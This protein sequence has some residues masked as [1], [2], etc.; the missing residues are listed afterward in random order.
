MKKH[1][2]LPKKLV[3]L[4]AFLALSAALT[5]LSLTAAN[6]DG[7]VSA[8][9]KCD[10]FSYLIGASSTGWGGWGENCLF[11]PSSVDLSDLTLTYQGSGVAT[12]KGEQYMDGDE[13]SVDASSGSVELNINGRG[14][15][16]LRVMTGGS[17]P[18]V[19]INLDGGD[20]AFRA[21]CADKS[22]EEP[23]DLYMVSTDGGV[24]YAGGLEKFKGHG[25]T[26]FVASGDTNNKN[27][28][29]IKLESKAELIPG[30]GNIKKWVL[31][32][33]RMYDGS[34]DS[35]GLSQLLAFHTFTGLAGDEY[36]GMK[37]E[38]VDLYVNGDYR[39]AYVLCE[40]MNDGGAIDV[41]DLDEEVTGEGNLRTVNDRDD[42]AIKLGVREYTYS[43]DASLSSD[44]TDIT[45][46]YVLEVMFGMYEGCGFV[47]KAGVYFSVK[48]PE[49]CTKEMVQYIAKKVQ[50]FENAISS[51]TG[52]DEMGLHYTD[53]ADM[54]SLA[55]MV[56]VYAFYNNFEYFRTSTYIY[57]DADGEPHD[58]LTF[59]PVWDFETTSWELLNSNTFFDTTFTY[60]NEQQYTWSE[61]LWQHGDFM[62]EMY[63]ENQK[64]MSVLDG[65]IAD[66]D[67]MI[68]DVNASQEMSARRW[69]NMGYSDAA[70]EYKSAVNHRYDVWFNRIWGKDNLLYLD[71]K[72][73]VNDDGTITMEADT[74][75]TSNGSYSW[76][77]LTEGDPTKFELF[78][79][80]SESVTVPSDGRLYFC[81]AAGNNNAYIDYTSSQ[82]FSRTDITMRSAPVKAVA[83]ALTP[84]PPPET[85]AETEAPA[86]EDSGGC[87]SSGGAAQML[88]ITVFVPAAAFI[89]K[90]KKYA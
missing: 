66:M 71:I 76:Y 16:I 84:P 48:S 40:R 83:E 30:S 58:K 45:G 8:V 23:G 20:D 29:N 4:T 65:V 17:I 55:D 77:V 88:I 28:Y 56:L 22:H 43:D 36:F 34:R 5:A 11:L 86:E 74:G 73:T 70:N 33:P 7:T 50:G 19:Y 25:F 57:K 21:V 72:T 38:Y 37:G 68:S 47:T 15:Y 81:A 87:G 12:Y 90:N 59:G 78:N 26:S 52:Y 79:N 49:F 46:G 42:P 64:M 62:A 85:E 13:F 39:G 54:K 31:L 3:L 24:I 75:G 67:T 35:T 14:Q 2:S 60:Y 41:T 1:L 82:F 10:G 32:S 80:R 18:S 9:I 63:R 69:G 53:Y 51:E 61:K 89:L 6:R 27:S 44:S